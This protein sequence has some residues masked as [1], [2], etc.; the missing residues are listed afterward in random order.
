MTS[1]PTTPICSA[2][3]WRLG[4]TLDRRRPGERTRG[5]REHHPFPVRAPA[6]AS[7]RWSSA[8]RGSAGTA[9]CGWLC[10]HFSVVEPINRLM[11][12]PPGKARSGTATVAGVEARRPPCAGGT[13]AGG[14]SSCRR[15]WASPSCG[16]WCC[17]PTCCRPRRSITATLRRRACHAQPGDLLSAPRWRRAWNSSSPATCSA[18]WFAVGCSR[19][20]GLDGQPTLRGRLACERASDCSKLPARPPV[21]RATP[22][23]PMRLRRATSSATCPP[24]PSAANAS[25]PA[26]PTQHGQPAG[27][28]CPGGWRGGAVNAGRAPRTGDR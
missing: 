15:R 12:S 16:R 3:K 18:A 17:S 22:A 21:R 1:T 9:V 28:C 24:A 23:C 10:P 5:G 25:T 6:R 8:R 2:W 27:R 26:R 19:A 14:A 11:A 4:S 7:P 20:V 13:R